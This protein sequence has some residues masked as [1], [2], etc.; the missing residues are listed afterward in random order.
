MLH[1]M[2]KIKMIS[3]Q[4]DAT[5]VAKAVHRLAYERPDWLPVLDAAVAVAAKVEAYGGDFAGAWVVQ[6]LAERGGPRWVPN[7]R[8]L[9]S[10]GLIEK[11]GPST[12]S[13]RRAYYR[14]PHRGEVERALKAWREQNGTPRQLRLIGAG[15][16]GTSDTA[17][18]AGEIAYEPRSWR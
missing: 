11:S 18:R 3:G 1:L 6:Q 12:R 5:D 2:T 14:M 13:G 9:A 4:Q 17:S 10:Y 16:S 15:A 8:I 7:L